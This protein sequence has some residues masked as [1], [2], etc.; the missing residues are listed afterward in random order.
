MGM[1]V[2]PAVRDVAGGDDSSTPVPRRAR[3]GFVDTLVLLK[4]AKDGKAAGRQGWVES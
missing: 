3:E 4:H 2:N 1:R